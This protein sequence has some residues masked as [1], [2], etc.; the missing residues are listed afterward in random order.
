MIFHIRDLEMTRKAESRSKVIA[1]SEYLWSMFPLVFQ[2]KH[3]PIADLHKDT[4]DFHI[5]EIQMTPKRSL[6]VK[7]HV[8][9]LLSR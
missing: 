6:K 3:M 7:G 5:L 9:L 2:C 1:D 4:A 8:T